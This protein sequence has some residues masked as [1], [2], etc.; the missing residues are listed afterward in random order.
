M[1]KQLKLSC[2]L[3]LVLVGFLDGCAINDN[4]NNNFDNQPDINNVNVKTQNEDRYDLND[5]DDSDPRPGGNNDFLENGEM[6][7]ER[8]K[9]LGPLQNDDDINFNDGNERETAD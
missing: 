6:D 5:I 4:N 1:R 7:E 9:Q 2:F 3:L 8:H